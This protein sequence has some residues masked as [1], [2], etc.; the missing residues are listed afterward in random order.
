MNLF[1][2]GNGFDIDHNIKSSYADFKNYLVN[3]DDLEATT[4]IEIMEK[5]H[6]NSQG[7]LWSQ[8]EKNLGHLNL[9]YVINNN[10]EYLTQ[11]ITLSEIFSKLFKGWVN[12]LDNE[13][14]SKKQLQ[15][16]INP[17]NDLF[18]TF[19]YTNTLEYIYNVNESNIKYIHVVKEGEFYEFGHKKIEIDTSSFH[20]N[21][22]VS[23]FFKQQ[24]IKDTS[25]IFQRNSD[26]FHG[27]KN[28][29]I[30]SLYFYGFSFADIDLI[31]IKG[32]LNNIDVKQLKS[33]HLYSYKGQFKDDYNNQKHILIDLLRDA[34]IELEVEKFEMLGD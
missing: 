2:M 22:G 9:D 12:Q 4:C 5:G 20:Y 7:D 19:N 25:S 6:N 34:N 16:L 21:F 31:Y 8:L 13:R 24:L 14:K 17:T 26:W 29:E 32:I 10:F 11:T 27:L 15:Q 1:I 30:N 3:L 18:F 33:I 28:Y 23:N